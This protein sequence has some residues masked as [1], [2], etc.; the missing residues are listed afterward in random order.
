MNKRALSPTIISYKILRYEARIHYFETQLETHSGHPRQKR[1]Y[2][3]AL[4]R[5]YIA[6]VKFLKSL[7]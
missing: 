2:T 3:E 4:N 6:Y 1:Y 7:P 5:S